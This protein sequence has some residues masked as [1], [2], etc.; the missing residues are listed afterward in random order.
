MLEPMVPCKTCRRVR[1]ALALSAI[2]AVVPS[3][4]ADLVDVRVGVHP[5][6]DRIVFEFDADV[7]RE[8]LSLKTELRNQ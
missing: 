3:V 1:R 7:M 5:T 4:G 8:V 6:F 2:L